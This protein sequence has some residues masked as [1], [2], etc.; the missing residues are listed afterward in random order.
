MGVPSP[1]QGAALAPASRLTG[2]GRDSLLSAPQLRASEGAALTPGTGGEA[3]AGGAAWA[4]A[5]EGRFCL[6]GPVRGHTAGSARTHGDTGERGCW[7]GLRLLSRVTLRAWSNACSWDR[8][9]GRPRLG[10]GPRR[11][12]RPGRWEA[13]RRRGLPGAAFESVWPWGGSLVLTCGQAGVVLGP[14]GRSSSCRRVRFPWLWRW[15]GRV[16]HWPVPAATRR[17][18]PGAGRALPLRCPPRRPPPGRP[19]PLVPAGRVSAS[20]PGTD[21]CH[22]LCDGFSFPSLNW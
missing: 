20:L 12:A 15:G 4:Q 5:A 1:R 11:G 6:R 3:R 2:L 21:P 9:T 14:P 10:S 18:A 17:P 22:Q 16:A 8:K 7:G 13:S 19:G